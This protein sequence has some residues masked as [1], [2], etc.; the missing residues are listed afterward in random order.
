MTHTH[1]RTRTCHL[2]VVGDSHTANVV[3]GGR[4]HLSGAAGSVTGDRKE[5][6]R[7]CVF[8]IIIIIIILKVWCG[9]GKDLHE[10]ASICRNVGVEFEDTNRIS[11]DF[12]MRESTTIKGVGFTAPIR[13]NVIIS[14]TLR[15][16]SRF[17]FFFSF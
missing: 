13:I 11:D 7:G 4:R 14:V 16:M 17:S 2:G 10:F 12:L 15:K 6:G 9:A 1:T 8:F 3:V 5:R